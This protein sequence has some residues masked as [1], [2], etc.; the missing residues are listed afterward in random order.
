[1]VGLSI[2]QRAIPVL[3]LPNMRGRD[4]KAWTAGFMIMGGYKSS[5]T[6]K[7]IDKVYND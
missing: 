2:T 4:E 3:Y 6:Y 5:R 7:Y 1:M